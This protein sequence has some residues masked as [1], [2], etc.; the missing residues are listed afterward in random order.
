MKYCDA[1]ARPARAVHV[2][3]NTKLRIQ[4]DTTQ[5]QTSKSLIQNSKI[6]IQKK[7]INLNKTYSY[8]CAGLLYACCEIA[9]TKNTNECKIRK[10]GLRIPD[11]C[12]KDMKRPEL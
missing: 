1:C 4:K 12:T 2:M 5:I 3:C 6:Q 10:R 9:N 8:V 7:N 11:V